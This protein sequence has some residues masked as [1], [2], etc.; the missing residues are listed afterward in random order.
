[1]YKTISWIVL[2]IK[3]SDDIVRPCAELAEGAGHAY[4]GNPINGRLHMLVDVTVEYTSQ[5]MSRWH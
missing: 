2:I 3:M 5:A 1:M 4:I